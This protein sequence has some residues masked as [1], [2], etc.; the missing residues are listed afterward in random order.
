MHSSLDPQPLASCPSTVI[1]PLSA[2]SFSWGLAVHLL[3]AHSLLLTTS[4]SYSAFSFFFFFSEWRKGRHGAPELHPG[5]IHSLL[6]SLGIMADSHPVSEV[7]MAEEPAFRASY[8]CATSPLLLLPFLPPLT[9]FQYSLWDSVSSPRCV[10][11]PTSLNGRVLS[12][13][14]IQWG[15]VSKRRVNLPSKPYKLV[16]I[17]WNNHE[18][19]ILLRHAYTSLIL[20]TLKY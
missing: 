1:S 11:Y 19:S 12:S 14:H 2:H 6:L 3:T 17:C 5:F 9:P 13:D 4:I 20:W 7:M 10:H 15:H 18:S 8:N 16:A